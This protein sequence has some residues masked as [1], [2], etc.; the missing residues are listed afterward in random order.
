M[1]LGVSPEMITSLAKSWE[2]SVHKIRST[3]GI[4]QA[5]YSNRP[6]C[7]LFDPGQGSTI[8][9]FLWLLC[10]LLISL[11][12]S[13]TAPK[14]ILQSVDKNVA[15]KYVGEAFVDDTGLGTNAMTPITQALSH[16]EANRDYTPL[17]TNL[18][19]LAQEWERLLFSTG[20]L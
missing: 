1:I 3:Y 6:D 7:L 5:Q 16:N 18:Q 17:V 15:T 19:T 8:G 14:S 4:S 2:Q 11:S 9:P 13:P 20:G 10:F 12:L